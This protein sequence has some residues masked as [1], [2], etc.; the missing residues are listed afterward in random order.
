MAKETSGGQGREQLA[1]AVRDRCLQ[2]LLQAWEEAGISGLCG[3]GRWEVAV[4]RLRGLSGQELLAAGVE[5]RSR[6]QSL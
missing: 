3:E 5:E 4:G 6:D 2:E 1:E